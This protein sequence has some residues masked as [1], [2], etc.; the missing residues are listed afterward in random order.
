M[1]LI[2]SFGMPAFIG[3]NAML[4]MGKIRATESIAMGGTTT[5]AAQDGE[6]AFIRN[7][8]TAAIKVAHGLVPD[9]S[10]TTATAQTSAYYGLG[11]DQDLP[12]A[13]KTGDKFSA[14]A[15]S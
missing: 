5:I 13:V 10:A 11:I 6:W 14:A 2:V 7:T 8:E 9:A 3:S 15:I 1:A 12:V 4:A